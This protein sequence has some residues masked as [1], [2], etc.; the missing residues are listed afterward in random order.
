LTSL[1]FSSCPLSDP[2]TTLHHYWAFVG[3]PP[4]NFLSSSYSPDR[5]QNLLTFTIRLPVDDIA[6]LIIRRDDRWLAGYPVVPVTHWLSKA[7][8]HCTPAFFRLLLPTFVAP[9]HQTTGALLL[10]TPTS[11]PNACHL[12]VTTHSLVVR[13]LLWSTTPLRR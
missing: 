13:L 3:V 2:A 12:A 10:R 7:S 1:R 6:P 11:T 8:H 9:W 4:S 5:R